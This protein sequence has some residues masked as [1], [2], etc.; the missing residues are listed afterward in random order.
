VQLVSQPLS[1]RL[2]AYLLGGGRSSALDQRRDDPDDPLG[3]G[4]SGGVAG[5]E[6]RLDA[7][8]PQWA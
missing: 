4:D 2:H 3:Q 7:D 5:P 8:H 1:E 6:V